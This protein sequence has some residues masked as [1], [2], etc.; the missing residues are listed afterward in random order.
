M[1]GLGERLDTGGDEKDFAW[2]T[3]NKCWENHSFS[4]AAG[5]RPVHTLTGHPPNKGE[6][7]K[8]TLSHLCALPALVAQNKGLGA[9]RSAQALQWR[10]PAQPA[11]PAP[12]HTVMGEPK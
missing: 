4:A 2:S 5:S 8:G 12:G 10:L 6:L 11:G 7:E 3:E 9:S 1:A